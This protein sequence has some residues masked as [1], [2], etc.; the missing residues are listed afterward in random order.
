MHGTVVV[1]GTVVA[2]VASVAPPPGVLVVSGG[3]A[4]WTSCEG[5]LLPSVWANP[6]ANATPKQ[7]SPAS[8]SPAIRTFDT[9]E[10]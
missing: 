9:A 6:T 1:T 4:S 7:S 8:T 2:V 10:I 5:R 3:T